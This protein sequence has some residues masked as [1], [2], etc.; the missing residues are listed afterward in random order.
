METAGII[1]EYDPMHTGHLYQLAEL[2]RR[3]GEDTA[4]IGVMSGD[5]VQRGEFAAAGRFARA[6]AAVRS[7]VDLVLELPL[8]WATGSAERFAEGGVAVLTG[9]G[10][11]DTLVFGSECGDGAAL[12]RLAAALL[13]ENFPAAL[14]A[15]LAAGDSFP[16]ARQRAAA[17]LLTEAEAD[18]LSQPNNILGVEYCKALLRRASSIRPV[19]IQRKG[20]GYHDE[21]VTED[22]PSATLIR[23][24]LRN[25]RR[26]EALARMAPAMAEAYREEERR[27]RAPVWRETCERA[28]LARLRTMDEADFAALDQGRE[29]LY[30]RMYQASREAASLDGVLEAAKTKRYPLARLRRMALWAYLGLTPADV[31]ETVPYLRVL[32]ANG[33]GRALLGRMRTTARLPV[34]TKPADVR[35]LGPEAERLFELEARA[36]DLYALAYP[37]LSA[38]VGGALWRTGPI[39]I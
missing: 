25:G 34:V 11:V 36:A 12:E 38:A 31:P 33:T 16:A 29:G 39:L 24:L 19:T 4:V 2:R 1:I 9:T 8:P 28:I 20:G 30:R 32:A 13:S 26:E 6:G 22:L 5:F 23:A 21:A 18:L 10:L 15:E 37:D 17:R 14:R 3:L 7:G 35:T 27:G